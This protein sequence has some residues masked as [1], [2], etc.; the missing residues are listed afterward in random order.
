MCRFPIFFPLRHPMYIPAGSKVELHF[1]RCI[2][3]TK[4]RTSAI[5]V[6]EMKTETNWSSVEG[7]YFGVFFGVGEGVVRVGGNSA[8]FVACA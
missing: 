1:W 7:G 8:F 5:S 3:P 6:I 2:G 4:V